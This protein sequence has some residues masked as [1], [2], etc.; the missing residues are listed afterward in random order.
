MR[1]F[2]FGFGGKSE[3]FVGKE[4]NLVRKQSSSPHMGRH[5]ASDEGFAMSD[6]R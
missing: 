4:Q 2:C 3:G 6:E 1:C 5:C